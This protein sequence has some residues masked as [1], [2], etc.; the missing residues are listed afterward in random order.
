MAKNHRAS[1]FIC[2]FFLGLT[3]IAACSSDEDSPAGSTTL[4]Q[5]LEDVQFL[6]EQMPLSHINLFH[7]ISES[8]FTSAVQE[9][10]DK[11]PNLSFNQFVLEL[12]KVT[13]LISSNGRD[14]HTGLNP[15][16]PL[17]NYHL[18]PIEV[19]HF[20]DGLYIVNATDSD[21][22]GSKLLEIGETAVEDILAD[23][24]QYLSKDNDYSLKFTTQLAMVFA[25]LLH[26]AGYIE[27]ESNVQIRIEKSGG[28]LST[29]NLD[30]IATSEY[31]QL[32]PEIQRL[33]LP[34]QSTPLYLSNLSE[35]FWYSYEMGSKTLYFQYNAVRSSDDSGKTIADVSSEMETFISNNQVDQMVVDL[36][37]NEGG[38]NTTYGPLLEMLQ[39]SELN[40][41]NNLYVIVGRGTFSAGM[42]FATALE[43]STNAIFVGEPTGGAPNHYGDALELI[44]PNTGISIG[45]S[46]VYH[47]DVAANDSR[48]TISPNIL[49]ELTSQDYF[50]GIDPAFEAIL[51]Q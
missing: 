41:Q 19:F 11:L 28:S 1:K 35:L 51:N 31:F 7:G 26:A 20:K 45:L 44:L 43:S 15:S 14:G 10:K 37:L 23:I 30:P 22:I 9:L 47:M 25:E 21:L 36:R 5:W 39:T 13:A 24:S 2:I 4:D 42:N 50:N 8:E 49:V 27:N 17:L 34:E 46:S 33:M 29:H 6:E 16:Q 3:L 40:M 48:L 12:M 18:L 38:D 32:F